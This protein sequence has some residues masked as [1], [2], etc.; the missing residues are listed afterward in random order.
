MRGT[1]F[2]N[3]S[4]V[5]TS[6]TGTNATGLIR[7]VSPEAITELKRALAAGL[8]Q[9]KPARDIGK[10]RLFVDR[11]FTLRGIGTI[12][13]GTL[14]GGPLSR[15]QSVVLQPQDVPTRA[16]SIQNHSRAVEIAV[17]GTR[18][19]LNL[20]DVDIGQ[21]ERGNVVSA[22]DLGSSTDCLEAVI[23]RSNRVLPDTPAAR[24]IKNRSSLY[25]HHGTSRTTARIKLLERE[26]LGPGERM[27][28][29]LRLSSPIFAFVG[30]R[31]ILRDSSQQFTVSGGVILARRGRIPTD[32]EVLAETR[33]G[34]G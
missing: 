20:A 13:T 26:T 34:P 2:E 32:R 8:S 22:P 1:R 23:E 7:Q 18:T 17:P 21:I 11:A 27:L 9:L 4:I 33:F 30:D 15:E 3:S 19:A 16:R 25:L 12:A 10:P 14:I 29:E 6:F 5:R 28:A 31:F 24:P